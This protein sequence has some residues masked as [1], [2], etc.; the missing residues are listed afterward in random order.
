MCS[1]CFWTRATHDSRQAI[2][3]L[4]PAHMKR[5]FSPVG[6]A[7]RTNPRTLI[8]Q[9]SLTGL[10]VHFDPVFPAIN[11]RATVPTQLL[12]LPHH[13][14]QADVGSYLCPC[15]GN[16]A[17]TTV[18]LPDTGRARSEK[19]H[20][21]SDA[22]DVPYSNKLILFKS[23]PEPRAITDRIQRYKKGNFEPPIK[24]FFRFGPQSP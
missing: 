4:F 8:D 2:Y 5:S 14:V 9:P 16:G 20:L 6:T 10:L 1:V 15:S 19:L 12:C 7:K 3:R 17:S 23:D 24:A 21:S 13:H 18:G 11:R 22:T